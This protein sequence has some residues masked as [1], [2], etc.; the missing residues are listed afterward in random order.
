MKIIPLFSIFHGARSSKDK[1][2]RNWNNIFHKNPD[3]YWVW[4]KKEF[5]LVVIAV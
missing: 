2:M 1:A 5:E 3:P 4:H